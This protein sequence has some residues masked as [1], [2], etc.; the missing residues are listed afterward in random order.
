MR[1]QLSYGYDL[2][3]NSPL[4]QRG[5]LLTIVLQK[6]ADL[7]LSLQHDVRHECRICLGKQCK[8]KSIRWLIT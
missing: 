8:S 2:G 7:F 6:P 4:N 1:V 5:G 3:G